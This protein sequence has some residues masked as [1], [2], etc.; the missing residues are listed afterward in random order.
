MFELQKVF[1]GNFNPNDKLFWNFVIFQFFQNF[2]QW[3]CYECHLYKNDM[4]SFSF[5]PTSPEW[6]PKSLKLPVD[7]KIVEILNMILV[8]ATFQPVPRMWTHLETRSALNP[9]MSGS[10]YDLDQSYL[11]VLSRLTMT[12]SIHF[13]EFKSI[14]ITTWSTTWS[15][16]S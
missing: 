11:I 12:N 7:D 4:P 2:R 15:S 3:K 16:K 14:R 1:F 13:L 9:D 6:N 10:R 5:E 8:E